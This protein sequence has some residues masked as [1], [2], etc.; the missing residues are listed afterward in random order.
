LTL[1]RTYILDLARR[2]WDK[3]DTGARHAR[4]ISSPIRFD[5]RRSSDNG[6]DIDC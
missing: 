5:P 4:R 3:G 2:L 1:I 6:R